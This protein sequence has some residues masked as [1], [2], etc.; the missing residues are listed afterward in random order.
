MPFLMSA[1]DFAD[2]AWKAI[3]R[4]TSWRR[5]P[6]ADGIVVG[7]LRLIPNALFDRLL[8]GRPRKRRR[9]EAP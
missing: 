3:E 9:V 8:A 6:V 4:G 2:R 1:A 5:H 7:L